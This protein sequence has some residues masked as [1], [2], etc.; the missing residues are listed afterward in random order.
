MTP[1]PAAVFDVEVYRNFFLLLMKRLTDGTVLRFQI[2]PNRALDTERL[3]KVLRTHMLVGF[4]SYG[5]D[6]PMI[7]MALAGRSTAELKAA[8]D[9][10]IL[11]GMS[12]RDFGE[13]HNLAKLGVN[14]IDL[15][16]VAPL[17]ASLK[18]YAGRLH[19]RKL[20]DL[21]IDPNKAVTADEAALLVQ[22]CQND[23]D[24]TATLY[25]ELSSQIALRE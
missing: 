1:Q 7:Q 21:P 22:Y 8:S 12:P 20:Q 11:G 13:K 6:L 5:Y 15:I 16:Q 19:C 24:N 17:K 9:E 18:I 25:E 2:S 14:H 10:L 4:N 3:W 23:L